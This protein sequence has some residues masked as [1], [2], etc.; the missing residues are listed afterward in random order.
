MVL[1]DGLTVREILYA[2]IPPWY[3]MPKIF[4]VV[5]IN[6]PVLLDAKKVVLSELKKVSELSPLLVFA[7]IR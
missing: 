2:L 5:S 1:A 6:F 3:G 4:H 7:F